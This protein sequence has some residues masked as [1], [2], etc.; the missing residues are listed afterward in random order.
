M[1]EIEELL[2]KY[3][4]WHMDLFE[5]LTGNVDQTLSDIDLLCVSPPSGGDFEFI[6][7]VYILIVH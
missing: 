7:H 2:F 3:A 6:M 5:W 1:K 4:M